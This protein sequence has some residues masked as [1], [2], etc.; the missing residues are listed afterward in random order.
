MAGEHPR[1]VQRLLILE[2]LSRVFIVDDPGNRMAFRICPRKIEIFDELINEFLSFDVGRSLDSMRVSALCVN[3]YLD[4]RH[5]CH[6]PKEIWFV[7]PSTP[8]CHCKWGKSHA[9]EFYIAG[10]SHEL[11]P[12]YI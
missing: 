10:E 6:S 5:N 3:V 2:S 1:I 12:L 7:T 4:V 9:P 8:A 11:N